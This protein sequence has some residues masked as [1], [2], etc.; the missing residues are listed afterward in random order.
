MAVQV[1]PDVTW[2]LDSATAAALKAAPTVLSA[3]VASKHTRQGS[4]GSRSSVEI[5][6]SPASPYDPLSAALSSQQ[7]RYTLRNPQS[8]KAHNE[9]LS[10]LPGGN[11]R[12]VLF[13]SPFPITWREGKGCELTSLDGDVYVDFLGEYTAGM[14]SRICSD[15]C[16]SRNFLTILL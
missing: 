14:I 11:T 7:A 15:V 6:R 16:I 3:P 13:S 12:T 8:L 4:R 10:Y 9:S 2:P 5:S 1:S